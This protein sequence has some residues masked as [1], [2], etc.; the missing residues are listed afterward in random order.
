M[1]YLKSLV[2]T[3]CTILLLAYYLL[4][5]GCTP[6]PQLDPVRTQQAVQALAVAQGQL[7]KAHNLVEA[8]VTELEKKG[9]K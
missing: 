4:L 8:R 5:T 3:V 2:G 6:K 9:K 1:K 7:Q